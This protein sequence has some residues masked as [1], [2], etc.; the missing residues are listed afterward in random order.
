M[1]YIPHH[2]RSS[3]RDQEK[4]ITKSSKFF[5]GIFSF[6][7]SRNFQFYKKINDFYFFIEED[8]INVTYCVSKYTE[9][10]ND[11]GYLGWRWANFFYRTNSWFW[12]ILFILAIGKYFFKQTFRQIIRLMYYSCKSHHIL[13]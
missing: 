5:T 7:I 1:S 2:K 4:G 10:N 12:N 11:S 13:I 6:A 8:S 3:L 9:R